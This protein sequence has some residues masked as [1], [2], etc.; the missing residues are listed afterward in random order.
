MFFGSE[1][2]DN[3]R[4]ISIQI[5]DKSSNFFLFNAKKTKN[6]GAPNGM[7]WRSF[8]GGYINS[9]AFWTA[10]RITSVETLFQIQITTCCPLKLS[11]LDFKLEVAKALWEKRE[12]QLNLD[13]RYDFEIGGVRKHLPIVFYIGRSM[14]PACSLF[15][16]DS[17]VF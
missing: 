11:R 16:V 8:F 1:R 3:A 15:M 6:N 10:I 17:L 4:Q 12:N 14:A 5:H 2:R 13:R 9:Q 7:D